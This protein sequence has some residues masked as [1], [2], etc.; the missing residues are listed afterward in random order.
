MKTISCLESNMIGLYLIEKDIK[1]IDI[2][3]IHS[4]KTFSHTIW[5]ASNLNIGKIEKQKLTHCE[6]NSKI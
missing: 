2:K 3:I 6:N 5:Y 4:T 1:I